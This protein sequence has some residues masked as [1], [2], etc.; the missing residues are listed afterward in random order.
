MAWW[1]GADVFAYLAAHELPIH[2]AYGMS[3]G[4]AIERERLRVSALGG[5]RGAEFGRAT[6]EWTYYRNWLA[7]DDKRPR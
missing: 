1:K 4:G 6:I 7:H 2:P 5:S 3:L